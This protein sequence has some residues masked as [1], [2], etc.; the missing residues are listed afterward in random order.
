MEMEVYSWLKYI[1]DI[2]YPRC[3]PLCG[4][5][6]HARDAF[7]EDCRSSLPFN[8]HAC[9]RC[10]IPLPVEAPSGTVCGRCTRKSPSFELTLSPLRYEAPF[11][12]LISELKFRRKL[13][14]VTPLA[15]LM[16]DCGGPPIPRPDTMIPVPLHPHRLQERGFN[17]SLELAR[18]LAHHY[19]LELDWRLCR[20][21]RSTP[22]QSGL[23]EKERRNNLRAA[24]E[25]TGK[26][27]GRHL[28]LL[29]DVITTGATVSS[30]SLAL[31]RAGAARIDVWALARTPHH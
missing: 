27:A 1:Q 11:S 9:P 21:V 24:F 3:C 28:L 22:A 16:I 10:A 6:T 2:C 15:R 23:S 5:G 20:R 7:C 19:E 4:I 14:L 17:Q 8:D 30:L 25:V 31:L 13:H 29:D 18:V 26:I 12:H